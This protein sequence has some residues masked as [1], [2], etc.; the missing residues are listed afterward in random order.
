MTGVKETIDLLVGGAAFVKS[1]VTLPDWWPST[2]ALAIGAVVV[3]VLL[4]LWGSR[5]LR[6]LYV[7]VFLAAGGAVGKR[8]AESAGVDILIGLVLGAG[9]AGLAG[10]L[11]FRWWVGVTAACCAAMLIVSVALVRNEADVQAA[12]KE[13]QQS[14]GVASPLTRPSESRQAGEAAT[15]ARSYVTG[16]LNYFWK[17]HRDVFYRVAL[18]VGLAWLTGLGMGLT[19]PRFTT[20]LGTSCIGVLLIMVGAGVLSSVYWSSAWETIEGQDKWLLIGAGVLLLFSLIWQSRHRRPV[21][22]APPPA[23]QAPA[24]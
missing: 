5:L 3:G 13:Y 24:A 11:L 22:T 21:A 12:M 6:L 20:I 2:V 23:P 14:A 8:V 4:A 17:N 7:L 15:V 1:H 9:L 10:Y 18:V 16:A 19:L